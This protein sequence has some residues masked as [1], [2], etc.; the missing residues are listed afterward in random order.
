MQGNVHDELDR[1]QGWSKSDLLELRKSLDEMIRQLEGG[2]SRYNVMDFE[3]IARGTLDNVGGID[4][5][6][7]QERDSWDG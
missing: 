1:I 3:G 7:K 4:E 6:I 2:E 5:F